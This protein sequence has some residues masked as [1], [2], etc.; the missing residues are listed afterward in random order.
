MKRTLK[1][2]L[3]FLT[4]LCA[5]AQGTWAQNFDVWDGHSEEKPGYYRR[6]DYGICLQIRSAAQMAWLMNHYVNSITYWNDWLGENK[7]AN[8]YRSSIEICADI[9]MTAGNWKPLGWYKNRDGISKGVYY[10]ANPWED[11]VVFNGLGHTVKIKIENATENYQGL[12]YGIGK[13]AKVENLH[14]DCLIKVGNYRLVGGICGENDGTIENC[15]VSGHIESDHYS[16]LDA[17]LGGIAGLND[18]GTIKYCCVTANVKNTDKN[19]GVGGIAG[20]NDGTI[21]HVTFYGEVS[22]EHSQDNKWVGDQDGTLENNYDSFNQSEYDAASDYG[23]Y[24]RVLKYMGFTSITINNTDEWNEMAHCVKFGCT[25]SGKY[26]KLTNNISVSTMVGDSETNSFQGTFDGDGHTLSFNKSDFT[27]IYC[28]PFRYVGNATF[29]NLRV[30]GT[31]N[32]TYQYAGGMI[33]W[34][35]NGR[36]VSIE[37]CRSSVT[38]KSSN[39]TN[40]GFVSRLGDNA[41]L[42]IS[43]SVFDGSFEGTGHH[44]GGFVGY[45]QDGSSATVANSLFK[46]DHISCDLTACQTF[47]RG[48]EATITNCYYTQTL[49]TAQGT[50]AVARATAPGNLGKLV[51]DYGMVKAYENGILF[52]DKCYLNSGMSI[53]GTGSE[54]DPYT[55]GSAEEWDIFVLNTD[56]YS[57]YFA[58]EFVKLT[59][60]I[61][62]TTMV[63]RFQG[64][65]DGDGHTLTVNITE[66]NVFKLGAAP[67]RVIENATIKNL[68]T[69]GTVTGIDWATHLAGVVGCVEENATIENCSSSVAISSDS[70]ISVTAGGIVATVSPEN[71]TESTVH[72]TGCAFTGSITYSDSR[73]HDGA[74]IVAWIKKFGSHQPHVNISHCLFAPS[75][76]SVSKP[77]TFKAIANGDSPSYYTITDCYY[78]EMNGIA[79]GTKAVALAAAPGNLGDLVKDY[80]MLKAYE[81]GIFFDGKYY[82]D[83]SKI[84]LDDKTDNGSVIS[85]L[86]GATVDVTLT[87]CTFYKDGAWNTVCLPFNLTLAGSPL[88]GAVARPLTGASISG[89][90]L[91]LTFGDAV[92]E[93][94]AGTPYI[95][96][97]ASGD[98]IVNPKF[99][100]VTIDATDRSFDNGAGGDARVRFIG[101]YRSIAFDGEDKSVLL[102]GGGNALYHPV[103]GAGVGAL[104]AYFKIGDSATKAS[105]SADGLVLTVK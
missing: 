35:V 85:E 18:D 49:G 12:F 46:P 20:S 56:K 45:C 10:D 88:D 97:W 32:T 70:P 73:G 79:Q 5:V 9:D 72:I 4:L 2:K 42:T 89:S 11:D 37:N 47:S 1:L 84:G 95:I 76:L 7:F 60:D 83:A 52:D 77:E 67:F 94:K 6:A 65:F 33:G 98:N 69:A 26:V 93:L 3:L 100:G 30:A 24:R 23:M 87:G 34:I 13:R 31:I 64:T 74:G 66:N 59:S 57:H 90:S 105:V 81:S 62:V 104:R 86:D 61:S 50:Q 53:P 36:T 75:V 58:G 25:L 38:I 92:T 29:R 55:I 71:A 51:K 41:V 44:S 63:K 103:G 17:D 99:N 96:K 27:G 80:G 43:G 8:P 91:N 15:W 19:Y 54:K 82:V 101:V 68:K 40:G 28:A 21:K 78:T 102:L 48:V 22:V 14:L 16:T 39:H